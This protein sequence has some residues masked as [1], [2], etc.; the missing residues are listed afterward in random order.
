MRSW[1]SI[2]WRL[3]VNSC[4]G[5]QP[6]TVYRSNAGY[7][8][9]RTPFT[10]Y[11]IVT[12]PALFSASQPS[13]LIVL[14]SSPPSYIK[15]FKL[16]SKSIYLRAFQDVDVYTL[17]HDLKKKAFVRWPLLTAVLLQYDLGRLLKCDGVCTSHY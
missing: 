14:T 5:Y 8:L 3:L 17:Y 7:R 4:M 10:C 13:L 2:E 12:D 15:C 11:L 1:R 16:H 9:A 6:L